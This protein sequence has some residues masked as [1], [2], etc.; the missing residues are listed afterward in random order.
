MTNFFEGMALLERSFWYIAILSSLIFLVQTILTFVGSG[1]TDGLD[2]DFDG[3]LTHTEAPFQLFTLRNLVNFMLGFGWTGVLFYHSIEYTLFLVLLATIV[4]VIF[5]LL[6]FMLIRQILKLTEDNTFKIEQLVD[7]NGQVYL[8]IPAAR[9]GK[10]KIQISWNGTQHEL[11]AMTDGPS[12]VSGTQ[13]RVVMIVHG[14][15]L[16]QG[17]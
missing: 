12:L 10:G 3:D 14:V 2:A 9:S 1:D 16:V 13:I 4:G 15:L 6:F 7:K 11:E 5:V 17:I 8:T